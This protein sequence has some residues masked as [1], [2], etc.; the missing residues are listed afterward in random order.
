MVATTATAAALVWVPFAD[1][2]RVG[3]QTVDGVIRVYWYPGGGSRHWMAELHG[4]VLPI[5]AQDEDTA[6]V[7]AV[8]SAVWETEDQLRRFKAAAEIIKGNTN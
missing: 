5:H 1:C 3:S 7:A 4:R 6:R 2:H 8:R